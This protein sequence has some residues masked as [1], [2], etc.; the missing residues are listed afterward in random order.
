MLMIFCPRD[1]AVSFCSKAVLD[2][3]LERRLETYWSRP[4]SFKGSNLSESRMQSTQDCGKKLLSGVCFFGISKGIRQI[5]E[6]NMIH[7]V[8][9]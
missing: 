2:L 3:Q 8:K 6:A 7:L 9:L 1:L 5:F 4:R